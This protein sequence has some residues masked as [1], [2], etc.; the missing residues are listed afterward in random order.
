[1]DIGVEKPAL[2]PNKLLPMG[3]R[4]TVKIVKVNKRVSA[5][6]VSSD[7]IPQY[8]GYKVISER[9]SIGKILKNKTFDL[10]IATS[11][12]G[13]PFKDV[14]GEIAEKW[15]KAKSILIAFGS[16]TKGLHE[17]VESEGLKLDEI[18]DFTVNTIPN[19]GTE[20]V[21]TEEALI[22][23]LAVLN[24]HTAQGSSSQKV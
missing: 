21:R 2:I 15:E 3:R 7:E 6:L 4:V 23:S 12:Y 24:L 10:K 22:A 20:T 16:P 9:R 19:Q 13:T 18:V 14:A 11:K 8:W 17:I 5:E 1:V